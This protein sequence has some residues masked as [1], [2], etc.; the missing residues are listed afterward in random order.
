MP[1]KSREITSRDRGIFLR[2]ATK[3]I[4]LYAMTA[5]C[6]LEPQFARAAAERVFH[7][8]KPQRQSRFPAVGN[9]RNYQNLSNVRE[10]RDIKCSRKTLT[11]V[12]PSRHVPSSSGT[13]PSFGDEITNLY[14]KQRR[15]FQPRSLAGPFLSNAL[16]GSLRRVIAGTFIFLE[17]FSVLLCYRPGCANWLSSSFHRLSSGGATQLPDLP[18]NF[19]R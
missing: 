11:N 7:A 14:V 16:H 8:A 19:C 9:C 12:R 15:T 18:D 4:T 6:T 1:K 13:R 10:E 3:M 17:D 2:D 5:R